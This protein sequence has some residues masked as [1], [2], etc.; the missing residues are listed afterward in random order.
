MEIKREELM[1]RVKGFARVLEETLEEPD[2]KSD[3]LAKFNAKIAFELLRA[4][5]FLEPEFTESDL[6]KAEE[7]LNRV[8][9]EITNFLLTKSCK[10]G[11]KYEKF[12]KPW[13]P[14]PK[15]HVAHINSDGTVGWY[16]V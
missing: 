15:H 9:T 7:A 12:L 14:P 4:R 6:K 13:S 2:N 10:G 11:D 5:V 1:L 8:H 16:E 3:E